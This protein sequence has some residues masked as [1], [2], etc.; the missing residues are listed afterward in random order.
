MNGSTRHLV[1]DE[2][3]IHQKGMWSRIVD[4]GRHE[5]SS[6]WSTAFEKYHQN[7]DAFVKERLASNQDLLLR[8]LWVSSGRC[9]MCLNVR[10]LAQ[11][12][13]QRIFRHVIGERIVFS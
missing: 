3:S 4:C 5:E 8:R 10:T 11:G 7:P 1:L 6:D 12:M 13:E 2:W 9:V